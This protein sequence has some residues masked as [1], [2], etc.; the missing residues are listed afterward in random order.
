[1]IF[2]KH[3]EK[4]VSGVLSAIETEEKK[5]NS[6]FHLDHNAPCLRFSNGLK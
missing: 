5:Q 1:M 6:T 4:E 2:E 3:D